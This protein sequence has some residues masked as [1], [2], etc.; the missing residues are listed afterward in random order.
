[1]LQSSD[2]T[3]PDCFRLEELQAL[4]GAENR[5]LADVNYYLWTN[6][7]EAGEAPYRFLYGLELIFEGPTHC[8]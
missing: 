5:V 2:P 3:P 8:S 1:M 4:Q 6:R 7:V